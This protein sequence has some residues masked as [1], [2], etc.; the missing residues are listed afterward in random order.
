MAVVYAL[1]HFTV[2]LLSLQF[3]I[4]TDC[5][6]LRTTLKKRFNTANWQMIAPSIGVHL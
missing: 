3:K 5:S 1:Q 4:V 2:Y 6:A